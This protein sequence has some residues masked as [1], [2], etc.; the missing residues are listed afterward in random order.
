MNGT[1]ASHTC[2]AWTYT[3]TVNVQVY[4]GVFTP[5]YLG[6]LCSE[7]VRDAGAFFKKLVRVSFRKYH[8]GGQNTT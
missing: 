1:S 5:S 7:H 6:S 8:K 2:L 3:Y 4:K